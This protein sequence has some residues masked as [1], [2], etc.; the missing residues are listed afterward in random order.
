MKLVFIA[1]LVTIVSCQKDFIIPEGN[2]IQTSIAS[3]NNAFS[4]ASNVAETKPHTYEPITFSIS[5]NCGGFWK[6]LPASYYSTTI[7]YPLIIYLTGKSQ[8]GDGSQA[9]LPKLRGPIHSSLLNKS[10]PPNFISGG[11][12]YSFIVIT[13]QFIERPTANEVNEVVNYLTSTLRIDKSRIYITGHSMGG[14][15]AWDYAG[16]YGSKTAAIAPVCAA[17]TP[18]QIKAKV[19][20]SNNVAAWAFHNELD[21]SVPVENTKDFV[22]MI[23]RY[24]PNVPAKMT[25][26][27]ELTMYDKN[28][29][30]NAWT[31]AYSFTRKENNMNVYEWMLQYHK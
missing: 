17:H 18:T 31:Y 28:D 24:R 8:L 27:T 21:N 19:I 22:N 6:G 14:G 12:N 26:F 7:K 15:V 13:P 29:L 10:F 1:F 16:K 23:N 4:L 3:E 20:A 2:V 5:A 11:K 30:H 25:I 9:D